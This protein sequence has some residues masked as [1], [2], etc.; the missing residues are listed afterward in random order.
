VRFYVAFRLEELLEGTLYRTWYFGEVKER[1]PHLTDVS[2][3]EW[4][5]AAPYLTL[6]KKDAPPQRR[7]AT[8]CARCS[9]RCAGSC[10]RL[11][12]CNNERQHQGRWCYGKTPM[13]TFWIH[14]TS[15]GRRSFPIDRFFSIGPDYLSDRVPAMTSH[16]AGAS[17]PPTCLFASRRIALEA[18]QYNPNLG[19]R[20]TKHR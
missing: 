14:C 12:Q 6:M 9:M 8:N 16:S 17:P 3:E 11:D 4:Y 18:K 2:D 5:F 7:Y 20:G 19:L 1:R 10:A 13:R 15:P